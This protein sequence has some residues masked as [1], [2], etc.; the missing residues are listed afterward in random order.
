M[1]LSSCAQ[2]RE[3]EVIIDEEPTETDPKQTYEDLLFDASYIHEVE[4]SLDEKDWQELL[5]HPKDKKKYEADLNI[6]GET[7]ESVS[8]S[9][10]GNSSLT[11]VAD[12]YDSGRYS[13][14][15]AFGKNIEGQDYHGLDKL[16]LNNIFSDPTY[17]KD[18]ICYALFREAG[19]PAP[20]TSY[21]RLRVN[22]KP[23]G[24]Y[25]AVE[26][27]SKG[28]LERNF[29][30]QG[31][32]YKPEDDNLDLAKNGIVVNEGEAP[33]F[34]VDPH[35][36]DLSYI[37]EKIESYPDIFDNNE[38]K[39]K[40]EDEPRVIEAL[41]ALSERK[42]LEKHL[43]TDEIIRYFA[44][45]DLLENFDSYTG[46]MLHN[47]ILHEKDGVL[48]MLPWDYNLAFGAF[49]NALGKEHALTF[50]EL[51]AMDIDH[52]LL[53]CEEEERP[54][55]SWIV[56]DAKYL[57]TYHEAV[58]QILRELFENG[59]FARMIDETVELIEDDVGNDPTA[60]YTKEEF[61]EACE[62]LKQ[63][64]EQRA[65]NV[66]SQLDAR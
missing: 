39:A 25:M 53:L 51:T 46:P 32:L 27:I 8:F 7:Y 16:N 3:E 23:H 58:H 45:H 6:D 48:A 34:S 2:R 61:L 63:F 57:E 11:I 21:V 5:T 9:T 44:L 66:R 64:A 13:F 1:F 14:K 36:A 42:D 28:F 12:R 55:F 33:A 56:S 59:H 65:K 37:D 18:H 20:L 15:I 52:P 47:Y 54:M 10:K 29:T 30:G 35:G 31:V 22:G 19:V 41:K 4:V 38:T 49:L 40:E 17:M 24:L 62:L 26:D 60:F 43:D 50:E